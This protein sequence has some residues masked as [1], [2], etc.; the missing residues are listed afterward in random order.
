MC[1]KLQVLDFT[2]SAKEKSVN[3]GGCLCNALLYERFTKSKVQFFLYE[4]FI[5]DSNFLGLC[6]PEVLPPANAETR[7]QKNRPSTFID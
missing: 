6:F 3:F 4:L 1:N 7:F 2:I 5:K